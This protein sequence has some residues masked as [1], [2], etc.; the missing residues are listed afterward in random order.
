M[1]FVT[2]MMFD[3]EFPYKHVYDHFLNEQ[4]DLFGKW[5]FKRHH[6]NLNSSFTIKDNSEWI[7]RNYLSSKMILSASV[8]VS[9]L[10]YAFKRNLNIT[11]PYLC[12]Y[13]IITCCR[14]FLYVNPYNEWKENGDFLNT[15]HSKII[16]LTRDYLN[17]LDKD[18][19]LKIAK[20]LNELKVSRELFSYKF[21]STGLNFINGYDI[22]EIIEICST[23]CELAQL[24]SEQIQKYVFKKCM[25]SYEEWNSVDMDYLK[26][27]FS[28]N[29]IIDSEDRYRIDYIR[30]KQPFPA[31]IYYTLTEGMVEDYFGA[32]CPEEDDEDLY[33]PDVNWRIL[34]PVP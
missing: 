32:W 3:D 14:A 29:G 28:Y 31:S 11:I 16:N 34:F 2:R 26:H 19:A 30:R 22:D 17:H 24:T 15:T 27:T 8:M 25:D 9:S 4:L 23:L 21:P 12:Y 7:T 6:D 13:S 33:N 5:I 20:I 1:Q 18:Y 10:E